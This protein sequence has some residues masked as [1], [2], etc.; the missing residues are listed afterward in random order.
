VTG[1]YFAAY[2][3]W[4]LGPIAKAHVERWG[5]ECRLGIPHETHWLEAYRRLG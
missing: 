3:A 2:W 1:L 4:R 5:G